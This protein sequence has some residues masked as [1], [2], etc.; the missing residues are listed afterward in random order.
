MKQHVC[1][2]DDY[3]ESPIEYS[4][5]ESQTFE[6]DVLKLKSRVYGVQNH[7]LPPH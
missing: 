3:P 2:N 5:V 4:K 6:A 7:S 1:R